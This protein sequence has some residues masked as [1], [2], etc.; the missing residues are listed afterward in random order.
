MKE[1]T[2]EVN[3]LVTSPIKIGSIKK[4][5]STLVQYLTG[6]KSYE[7]N[8]FL[9]NDIE[10]QKINLGKRNKNTPTDVLSFP[11]HTNFPTMPHQI[12]GDIIISI[13][14]LK[15]QAKEIGHTDVDE[16]YRLL[17]H[18]LLHLLGYDHETSKED[19][20]IMKAKEDECLDKVFK[21]P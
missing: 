3:P 21:K 20:E 8:V 16:L 18:G 17:V 10:I 11:I 7:L 9:T 1:I 14:T 2:I 4:N 19:E 5:L 15:K 12:L 6:F 13:D